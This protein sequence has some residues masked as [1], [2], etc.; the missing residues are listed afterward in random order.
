MRYKLIIWI[1]IVAAMAVAFVFC[2][3]KQG[4]HYDEN[5]SYYSTN[6]TYGLH[7][8]DGEWKDVDEIKSEYMALRGDSLN[9][10]GVKLSQTYDVH[11]PLYY[12]ILR[13]V[14][15]LTPDTFSKWQGLAIN[16]VFYLICLILLW[17]IAEYFGG[18]DRYVT[19]FTLV[20]FALSP[21]YLSTVTF[22]RMYVMLTAE[23]FGILLLHMYVFKNP[24]K[25]RLL[26]VFGALIAL[27]GFLTHYYSFIFVFFLTAYTCIYF[28]FVKRM[29]KEAIIYGASVV[30]ALG[31]AIA[32]YP[33][34]LSH[35]FSGYRGNEATEAFMDISNTADRFNFFVQILNDYTFSGSFFVLAILALLIYLFYGYGFK[36]GKYKGITPDAGTVICVLVTLSY[37][38]VVC[39]TGMMPSNPPEALRYECPVYGLIILITVTVIV[40]LSAKVGAHRM[41]AVVIL[42]AACVTQTVGLMHDKVFFIYED[43]KENRA[44][45]EEHA[46]DV[47]AYIYNPANEWMIWNDGPEL[48]NYDKIYFLDMDHEGDVKDD[49]LNNADRIYVYTCRSDNSDDIME[50]MIKADDKLTGFELVGERLFVDIYELR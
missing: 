6:V 26:Y 39:K 19:V 43:A 46:D 1:T 12:Y 2:V 3:K 47:I 18:D 9:L 25:I 4:F 15:F 44:W 24:A 27:A 13:I 45:S 22:I 49:I 40:K 42:A 38:L 10:S 31:L 7:P 17:K 41:I 14:C 11:P 48:M 29:R 20:L 34:M 33:A 21:G 28:F 36:K 23:C 30:A 50:E 35:I 37:F 8:F 16:L 5:Y 32:Y